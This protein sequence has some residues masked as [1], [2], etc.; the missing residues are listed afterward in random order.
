[1]WTCIYTAQLNY[2]VIEIL[3]P[4]RWTSNPSTLNLPIC[5][6]RGPSYERRTQPSVVG[7]PALRTCTSGGYQENTQVINVFI[8][9]FFYTLFF[10]YTFFFSTPW[11]V[12]GGGTAW[13]HNLPFLIYDFNLLFFRRNSLRQYCLDHRRYVSSACSREDQDRH[14][15][16][17]PIRNWWQRNIETVIKMSWL[18]VWYT[19]I[20]SF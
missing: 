11:L 19:I 17:L 14:V 20:L 8:F 7:L 18:L 16:S 6:S 4:S 9:I 10:W 12:L 13:G 5:V 2:T 15:F 1:M 3:P